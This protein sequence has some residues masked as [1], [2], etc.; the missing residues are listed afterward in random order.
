VTDAA[1]PDERY[2][3]HEL[4]DETG[5]YYAG[6]RFYDPV[7]GRWNG[8]DP[9]AS[10]RPA[11]SPYNYVRNNPLL[12]IDPTGKMD[13]LI[14]N[15]RGQII[16][17]APSRFDYVAVKY[18]YGNGEIEMRLPNSILSIGLLYTPEDILIPEYYSSVG[19]RVLSDRTIIRSN[20]NRNFAE[21]ML[22]MFGL[23]AS[24]Q[25]RSIGEEPFDKHVPPGWVGTSKEIAHKGLAYAPNNYSEALR[26]WVPN[27]EVLAEPL[28]GTMLPSS[29]VITR[30]SSGALDINIATEAGWRIFSAEQL[31]GAYLMKPA[32]PALSGIMS[33]LETI[34]R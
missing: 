28:A 11:W 30:H 31:V 9:L 29:W 8:I 12:F 13:T 24:N 20:F 1:S 14:F 33:E 3:G 22:G 5:L 6:A 26:Y 21:G 2:T 10:Q 34:R 19:P 15:N 4:D 7:A 27:F 16:H 25:S 32:D 17:Y 23:H 18:M